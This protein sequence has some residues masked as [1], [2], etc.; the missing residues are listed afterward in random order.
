MSIN[1]FII[2]IIS[3]IVVII[4]YLI[5]KKI[6][7]EEISNKD[8]LKMCILGFCIG[9]MNSMLMIFASDTPLKFDQEIMTGTPNF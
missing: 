5:N 1:P 7:N 8:L 4:V 3:S 9:L 6:Y 2:A